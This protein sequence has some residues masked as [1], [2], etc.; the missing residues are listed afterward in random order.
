[1]T[2]D[3]Q[4][5]NDILGRLEIAWSASDS[6]S[7]AASFIEDAIFVHI[8]WGGQLDGRHAIDAAH[9]H[10]FETLYKG[11]SAS[12]LLRSIRFVR[13]DVAIVLVRQHVKFY[14]V[15]EAREI[16]TRPTLIMVKEEGNWHIVALQNTRISEVPA[17]AQDASRLAS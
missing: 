5:I 15:N 9:R 4:A 1:M 14:E 3:E 2:T 12:F 7:F 17:A 6:K 10:I 16:D 11:S 13:P 8:F